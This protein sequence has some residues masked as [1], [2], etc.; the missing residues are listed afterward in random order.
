MT[1]MPD[2]SDMPSP[3][4]A[5][6]AAPVAPE[7]ITN[8]TEPQMTSDTPNAQIPS[9]PVSP[10]VLQPTPVKKKNNIVIIITAIILVAMLVVLYIAYTKTKS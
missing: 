1:S 4:P 2:S 6:P 5:M 3:S 8:S 10:M 7:T 9:N